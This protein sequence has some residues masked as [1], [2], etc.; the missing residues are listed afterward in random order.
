MEPNKKAP[1]FQ[2][3]A[4]DFISSMDVQTMT[5]AEVGAYCLL[6]FNSWIGTRQGY[7]PNNERQLQHISRLS[8]E[9]WKQSKK[10]LLSK[11]PTTPDGKFR[12]NPR[13]AAEADKQ[14]DFRVRQAENG[15]RGG[16]PKRE[17][18][19]L[20]KPVE[21]QENPGLNGGL[22]SLNPEKALHL[23]SSSS[24]SISNEGTFVPAP[25]PEKKIEEPTLI[26]VDTKPAVALPASASHTE[27]ARAETR[28]PIVFQAFQQS[29][30]ATEEGLRA[31]A[32]ELKLPDVN[33]DYYLNQIGHKAGREDNRTPEA[34][35]TYATRFLLN[36]A[37]RS[38][39]VTNTIIAT[40][41]PQQPHATATTLAQSAG[42]GY[43]NTRPAGRLDLDA[44]VGIAGAFA[45][46]GASNGS[47][48]PA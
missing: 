16:R 2:L 8:P 7:I 15:K 43:R 3:Y 38:H 26:E 21:S 20:A 36:D 32:A 48:G 23:P 34:W 24:T 1:A 6:L 42:S 45:V 41:D 47:N 9:E 14:A 10:L 27:G 35:R 29:H 33:I 13:L 22:N 12:Y 19:P 17:D 4:Q 39:L 31:L 25:A 37:K 44:A 28:P 30:Y 40:P 11:F 46:R 5:A 18:K